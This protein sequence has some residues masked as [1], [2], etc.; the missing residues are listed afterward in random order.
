MEICPFKIFGLLVIKSSRNPPRRNRW[1]NVCTNGSMDRWME[2]WR[3]E[4]DR[5]VRIIGY[6]I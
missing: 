1:M 6:K 4:I 2:R 5:R 3:K